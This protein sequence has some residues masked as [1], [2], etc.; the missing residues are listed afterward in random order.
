LGCG[1]LGGESVDCGLSGCDA[2]SLVG[3]YQRYHEAYSLHIH[4]YPEEGG[5]IFLRNVITT[6]KTTSVRHIR[7][8][9]NSLKMGFIKFEVLTAASMKMAIFWVVAP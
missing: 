2:V 5:D 9:H 3:G 4:F 1:S 6:Y 8:Y 7:K